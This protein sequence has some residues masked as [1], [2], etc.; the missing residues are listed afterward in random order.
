LVSFKELQIYKKK[1]SK[2]SALKNGQDRIGH[3]ILENSSKNI[4]KDI[5]KSNNLIKTKIE[6]E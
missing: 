2:V 3:I 4:Y 5:I 1:N 6:Y